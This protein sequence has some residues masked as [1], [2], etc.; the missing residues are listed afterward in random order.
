MAADSHV[1]SLQADPTKIQV[2]LTS[3]D[4]A[5]IRL[6]K[7]S[8]VSG[9]DAMIVSAGKEFAH[10]TVLEGEHLEREW[11][12]ASTLGTPKAA[13]DYMNAARIYVEGMLKLMLRG[14][15]S[16]PDT[17]VLGSCRERIS[18][19]HKHGGGVSPW[20]RSEMGNL[21]AALDKRKPQIIHMEIAHHADGA[22]LAIAEAT[23]VRAHLTTKLLP[24]LD[25]CFRLVRQNLSLHAGQKALHKPAPIIPFPEGHRDSVRNLQFKIWGRV[26]ALTSGLA[27]DGLLSLDEY[28]EHAHKKVTLA[29]HAAYLLNS[30]TLEPV[31]DTGDIL[32]ALEQDGCNSPALVIAIDHDRLLARR[33]IPAA[34][35]TDIAVLSAQTIN[36][37]EL[38]PPVVALKATLAMRKIV[39]VIYGAGA[40]QGLGANS[41]VQALPGD[42][43]LVNLSQNILGLVEVMGRSAE[44]YALNGQ[45]LI[46]QKAIPGLSALKAHEGRPVIAIDSDGNRYFKRL[47]VGADR[48]VLESLATGGAFGPVILQMP[49]TGANSLSEAWPVLGVLFDVPGK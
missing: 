30:Q 39:G 49:G 35:D 19:L 22:Q 34:H 8:G 13:Q 15:I 17:Y 33:Y 47:H 27:A 43:A 7:V 16:A 48:V 41:E 12:N 26:A 9:R 18:I 14:E 45:Y 24:T 21:V 40:S 20:N 5:F 37:Y 10:I 46:V 42:G 2:I 29:Q 6:I 36:P 1:V 4:E 31:A 25:H 11:V 38:S 32:L 28:A 44:P 3:H 23:D